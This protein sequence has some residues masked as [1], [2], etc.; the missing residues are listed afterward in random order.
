MR[1][2]LEEMPVF[3]S[4]HSNTT[5]PWELCAAA[6]V[7]LLEVLENHHGALGSVFH[8]IHQCSRAG[9]VILKACCCSKAG[10]LPEHH[11]NNTQMNYLCLLIFLPVILFVS[12]SLL[13]EPNK[14]ACFNCYLQV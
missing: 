1:S 9:E 5:M 13:S 12:C 7:L 3:L 8:L 4:A 11:L 2:Q 10:M 6:S 14:A